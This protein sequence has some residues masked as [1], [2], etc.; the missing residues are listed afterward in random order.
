MTE[1]HGLPSAQVLKD[2]PE[3]RLAGDAERRLTPVV[4]EQREKLKE[5]M[6]GARSLKSLC[7]PGNATFKQQGHSKM[8]SRLVLSFSLHEFFHFT[9][10]QHKCVTQSLSCHRCKHKRTVSRQNV[11]LRKPAGCAGKLKD[12]GNTVLGKFGMSLDN[13]KAD[14]DPATGSYSISFQQ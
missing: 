12:L 13:F 11:V 6:L 9:K 2:H 8:H 5:E 1:Q 14:K 10:Q 3:N 7:L 4:T